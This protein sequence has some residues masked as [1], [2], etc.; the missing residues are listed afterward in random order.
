MHAHEKITKYSKRK[1]TEQE[2]TEGED[3][4]H[5]ALADERGKKCWGKNR[6]GQAEKMR[7]KQFQEAHRARTHTMRSEVWGMKMEHHEM[8]PVNCKDSWPGRRFNCESGLHKQSVVCTLLHFAL[9]FTKCFTHV[10][11]VN[12][13]KCS[14][15]AVAFPMAAEKSHL[16][17]ST[18]FPHV[19]L[20][21]ILQDG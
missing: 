3:T 7:W 11:L 21:V 10:I 14:A 13:H 18:L 4:R 19:I 9:P 12:P 20:K 6:W 5:W 2:T 1:M 15:K 16:L 8:F 17:R